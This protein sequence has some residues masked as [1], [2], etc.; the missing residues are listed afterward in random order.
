M[1]MLEHLRP[2]LCQPALFGRERCA[3]ARMEI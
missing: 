2:P 1:A 3:N